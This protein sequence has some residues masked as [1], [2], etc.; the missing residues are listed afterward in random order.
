M[1]IALEY[2]RTAVIEHGF[3]VYNVLK[4]FF[5]DRLID[6]L[7]HAGDQH[8]FVMTAI[9]DGQVTQGWHVAMDTP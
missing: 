8:F 6:Q 9:K 5:A 4:A 1:Q 3:K 7:M 2:R